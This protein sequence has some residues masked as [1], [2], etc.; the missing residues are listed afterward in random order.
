MPNAANIN[1]TFEHSFPRVI[2]RHRR[3]TQEIIPR[4][5]ARGLPVKSFEAEAKRHKALIDSFVKMANDG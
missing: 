2:A 1:P 4:R 5:K 3:L